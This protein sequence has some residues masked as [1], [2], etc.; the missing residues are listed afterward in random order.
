MKFKFS[1]YM[2]DPIDVE[3]E[4]NEITKNISNFAYDDFW[5]TD[6]KMV[7]YRKWDL[8][9]GKPNTYVVVWTAEGPDEEK[10]NE[11]LKELEDYVGGWLWEIEREELDL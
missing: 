10:I 5:I 11:F 6:L 9:P 7:V 3:K 1:A 4:L 2:T 8:I